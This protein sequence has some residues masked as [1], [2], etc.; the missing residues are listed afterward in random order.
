[1]TIGFFLD[2]GLAQPAARLAATA[3]EDGIG[4]SD[5]CFYLGGTDATRE[6]VAASDPGVDDIEVSIA[7][8]ADDAGGMA[9]LPS[10]LRLAATQGGLDT[11]MPGDPLAVSASIAGGAAHAVA[12]WVRIDA[13]A[14]GAAIYDNLTLATNALISRVV[15]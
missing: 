10:A 5:H 14:I 15:T 3:A 2:S 12:V 4:Y 6:H 9:L 8:D 11:A 13:P 1:M 7:D